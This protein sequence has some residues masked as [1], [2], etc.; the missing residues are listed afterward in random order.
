LLVVSCENAPAL[1][2]RGAAFSR[3]C[4]MSLQRIPFEKQH[5]D[6]G[7]RMCG[8]AALSMVYRS[9][10]L[11]CSQ[12]EAWG[13]VARRDRHGRLVARTHLLARDAIRRGLAAVVVQVA[14]PWPVLGRA[15]AA[16][17]RVILNHRLE[18]GSSSGH[19]TVLVDIDDEHVTLHDPR[20][21]PS[22]RIQRSEFLDLWRPGGDPSEIVGHVLV[23][24]ETR[25]ELRWDCTECGTEVPRSVA[26]PDCGAT[27]RLRPVPVLGCIREDCSNRVWRRVFCPECDRGVSRV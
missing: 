17:V 3:N 11:S 18:V 14:D 16:E 25:S 26:C 27:I 15:L 5:R 13:E 8:A 12:Q 6:K 24:I 22:R 20:L 10:D 19:Y 23:G 9:L 1:R 21:G 2:C 4:R 7:H